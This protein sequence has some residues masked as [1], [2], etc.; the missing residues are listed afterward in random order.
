VAMSSA[1]S[2]ETSTT[3]EERY[4]IYDMDGDTGSQIKIQ[5]FVPFCYDT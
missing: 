2:L 5:L 3:R 4:Y 1:D